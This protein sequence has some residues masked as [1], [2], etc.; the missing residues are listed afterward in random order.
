MKKPTVKIPN[1][2][3]NRGWAY[4]GIAVLLVLAIVSCFRIIDRKKREKEEVLAS[5]RSFIVTNIVTSRHTDVWWLRKDPDTAIEWYYLLES[6][7]NKI[8][9]LVNSARHFS[10]DTERI[11][12][13]F[14]SLR[15]GY[16]TPKGFGQ[17]PITFLGR[18]DQTDLKPPMGE[19]L[20]FCFVSEENCFKDNDWYTPKWNTGANTIAV[21]AV[22]IPDKIMTGV[23]YHELGHAFIWNKETGKRRGQEIDRSSDD[24][25]LEELEMHSMAG[26]I[27]DRLVDGKYSAFIEKIARRNVREKSMRKVV[28]SITFE[29]REGLAAMFDAQKTEAGRKL[30][31]TQ[32]ALLVG[33]RICDLN[34]QGDK[35]KMAV[36]RQLESERGAH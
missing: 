25:V 4:A 24:R 31:N 3:S 13:R 6:K 35:E 22:E 33:F 19:E 9:A 14:H 27:M 1:G 15:V 7:K 32:C 10:P 21:P 26:A 36:Y 29:E 23:I 20:G 12:A 28:A 16:V 8:Q 5:F 30:L 34:G 11:A 18:P 2:K 17:A